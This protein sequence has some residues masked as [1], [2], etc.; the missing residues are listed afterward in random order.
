MR[1]IH[2]NL[3]EH[4]ANVS[5]SITGHSI[6]RWEGNTLIVDTV[7]FEP[8]FMNHTAQSGFRMHSDQL[9]V[10]ERFEVDEGGRTL[11]RN[12]FF[13]DPLFMQGAYTGVDTQSL[14][15]E[16]YRPYD[17]EELSGQNNR[18]IKGQE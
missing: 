6:G 15:T 4:P 3:S 9:H 16:A 18:R 8:G 13:E 12:Y 11:T 1:T 14:S 2:L 10:V 17:C 5:P 7:G